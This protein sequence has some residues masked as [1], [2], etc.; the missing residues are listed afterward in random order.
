MSR[1]ALRL[2]ALLMGLAPPLLRR[3]LARRSLQEPG[4]SEAIDER[5]GRYTHAAEVASELIWIH[6][7]S[8]GETR[9]AAILLKAL[10]AQNPGL[11]LLL[12]HGTARRPAVL[13]AKR[14]CSQEMYRFGSRGIAQGQPS[15]FSRTSS[16][17]WAC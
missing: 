8:L 5:F 2:Y 14:F 7:V 4:Y 3:K 10:R 6:A 16:R 12:T 9:T 17:A 11:R 13:R 1:W 15:G